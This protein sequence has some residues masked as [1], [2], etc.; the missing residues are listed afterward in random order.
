MKILI[1]GQD[2]IEQPSTSEEQQDKQPEFSDE[3]VSLQGQ[4]KDILRKAL[5]LPV[6]SEERKELEQQANEL[7]IKIQSFG[8]DGKKAQQLALMY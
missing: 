2:P 6:G 1:K 5:D 3:L 8:I 7:L 4:R